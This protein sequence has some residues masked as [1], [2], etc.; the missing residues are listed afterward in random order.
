MKKAIRTLTASLGFLLLSAPAWSDMVYTVD[1]GVFAGDINSTTDTLFVL[2]DDERLKYVFNARSGRNGGA[3]DIIVHNDVPI[4]TASVAHNT[5]VN[6]NISNGY[7]T[8]YTPIVNAMHNFDASLDL[9]LGNV[10]NLSV[11]VPSLFGCASTSSCLV[12]NGFNYVGQKAFAHVKATSLTSLETI[13][14]TGQTAGFFYGTPKMLYSSTTSALRGNY[15]QLTTF[16]TDY[17]ASSA[18]NV[19]VPVSLGL[20]SVMGLFAFRRRQG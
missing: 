19:S 20:L 9:F 5:I 12:V 10:N 17:A 14:S 6:I 18:S 7:A 15:S 1:H 4:T 11:A 3:Y 2:G 13:V 8:T 16:A